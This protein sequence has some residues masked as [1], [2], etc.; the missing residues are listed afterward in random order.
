MFIQEHVHE[1]SEK[2]YVQSLKQKTTQMAIDN[3]MYKQFVEHLSTAMIF[4]KQIMIIDFFLKRNKTKNKY[5]E[6]ISQTKEHIQCNSIL[7]EV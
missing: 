5:S 3:S 6:E 7:N 4:T 2:L 1:Y